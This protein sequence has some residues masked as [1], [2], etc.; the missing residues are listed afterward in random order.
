VR[1]LLQALVL[2]VVTVLAYVPA[3]RGG[4]LWD[5]GE[6]LVQNPYVH[7][8]GG[9]YDIWLTDH[10]VTYAPLTSS[11]FW[12][13]W[14]L[15]GDSPVGYR[16]VSLLL[17]ALSAIVLWRILL[18]L[19]VPGAW[20]AAAVF[21]VHPVT[22]AS[23]A[24]IAERRNTL[25]LVLGSS[26]LL[27][28][29]R[30]EDE[31]RRVWY[32]AA[33]AAF[34]LAM[35]A[36]SSVVMLPV[37]ILAVIWYRRGA[38]TRVDVVRLLPFFTA[39]AVLGVVTLRFQYDGSMRPESLASRL[40]A[41]GWAVWFYLGTVLAPVRLTMV[42]P[43][44][45]VD[46]TWLPAW[47]PLLA[48]VVLASVCWLRRD[49]WGRPVLAVLVVFVAML[50]PV[51]GFVG[52][53][54]LE[55][56][57]VSDH[58]QYA[59]LAGPIALIVGSAAAELQRRRVERRTAAALALVPLVALAGLTWARATVFESGWALWRDTL[60]KNPAA[61]VAHNN[62]GR[63]L[64]ESGQL[65]EAKAHYR[66][67][68]DLHPTYAHAHNNLG[69]VLVREGR[70][71]EAE[72]E[73]RTALGL[74][75]GYAEAHSNLGNLLVR[76]GRPEEAVEHQRAAARIQPDSAEVR[77]N[78]GNGLL[79]LGLYD[80][81]LAEY[82]QALRIDAGLALAHYNRGAA[83]LAGGR[84]TEAAAAFRTALRIAPSL[85]AAERGLRLAE[86]GEMGARE[87][88]AGGR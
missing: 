68:I 18:R 72:T 46:P 42:Y 61:W 22:V 60:D 6:L 26:A 69:V 3:L 35:L 82:D 62:L 54:F 76:T 59:A 55:L 32:W 47:G 20:V 77:T 5:D 13:E 4:F 56:S 41:A 75:A 8:A 53:S 52:W 64:E 29:L 80:A 73:Y 36:K 37:V 78:L 79:Q 19:K 87:A 9:L 63:L 40:A 27:A 65:T 2:V 43:R 88:R 7:S 21:A 49:G 70:D 23:V 38:I 14:R 12:L 86:Q 58:L 83:L 17:H 33:L 16:V 67:A 85:A 44:W 24:W 11:M 28:F 39:A 45:H 25:S 57:L 31:E 15:W 50:L 71:A 48:L 74:D 51:L 1:P 84:S 10:L 30:F 66:E 81:A 34:V